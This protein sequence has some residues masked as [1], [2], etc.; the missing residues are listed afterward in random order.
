MKLELGAP[1]TKKQLDNM[2]CEGCDSLS[3][4]NPLTF[5]ARCHPEQNPELYYFDGQMVIVC[6]HCGNLVA[7]I[8]VKEDL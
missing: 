5:R 6:S 4:E 8:A 7:N 2:H 1:L 3:L